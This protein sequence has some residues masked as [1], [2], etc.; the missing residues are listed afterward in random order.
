M[1][2]DWLK[3]ILHEFADRTLLDVFDVLESDRA[4]RNTN[5]KC[6]PQLGR[7]GL[8]DSLGGDAS[9]RER[10]LALLWVLNLSDGSHSMLDVAERSG[11]P[12][13]R[14][15]RATEALLGAELLEE[16]PFPHEEMRS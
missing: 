8:Y 5:P 2:P 1:A 6:E 9:R 16:V 13:N 4:Y 15:R 12:F 10:E 7:R 11:M 14:I 3:T